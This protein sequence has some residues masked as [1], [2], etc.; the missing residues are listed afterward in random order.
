MLQTKGINASGIV[1]DLLPMQA[2][3][4][5][6]I[7]LAEPIQTV[8]DQLCTLSEELVGDCV[9]SVMAYNNAGTGL[10]VVSAPNLPDRAIEA[11]DGLVP[12]YG[13]GSCANAVATGEPTIVCDVMIDNVWQNVRDLAKQFKL[14]A[15]W[16]FPVYINGIVSGSFA[17]SSFKTREPSELH[18][19]LLKTSAHLAGLALEREENNKILR[20]SDLAFNSTS[21]GMMIADDKGKVYKSN[22]AY[23]EITGYT[24]ED[25][26][27]KNFIDLVSGDDA[28]K[29]EIKS[30][31][32][33][34]G[35]WRGEVQ[36]LRKDGEAVPV[37]ANISAVENNKKHYITVL[38]DISVL[39]ASE[40][41]LSY[42]A[43]HDVLT[44]L[45]NR[46][47]FEKTLED[48]LQ[49]DVSESSPVAVLFV[50]LDDFKIINDSQGH[51][52]GDKMLKQV[53]RRLRECVRDTDIVA[54]LGGD[55]F[56]LL[57]PFSDIEAVNKLAER[58]VSK[59]SQPYSI[60]KQEYFSSAS[61]GI[62][63]APA[64]GLTHE[65]LIKHADAAMYQ[66][67]HLGKN[68]FCFYTSDLTRSLQTRIMMEAGLRSAI[69]KS[70]F[71][72]AYQPRF[73][74][75]RKIIAV[76][77][78]LRWTSE[79]FGVVPPDEFIHL[80]ERA[81]IISELGEW[82]LLNACLQL[83]SW[84]D[85]GLD[86]CIS[87]NVSR[88]QLYRDFDQSLERVLDITGIDPALLELEIT[89]S[90]MLEELDRCHDL[91]QAINDKGVK[92]SIDDFGTGYSSLSDLKN[93]PVQS[94]KIDKS[95]VKGL[96]DNEDDRAIAH[97]VIAMGHAQK[98]NVV[99]EGVET[100]RQLESLAL[101]GCDEY[102]GYLL[103]RPVTADELTRQLG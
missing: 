14:G 101:M 100:D 55:E 57:V 68:R 16:S 41:R 15:C 85:A 98:L 56:T 24:A 51:A 50:D 35:N 83:K 9:A 66:A 31:I 25:I 38:S 59:I 20:D 44:D 84:T 92:I 103:S 7:A 80:A 65:V 93:L 75:E 39:K 1:A 70:E 69:Q 76:E 79:E 58:I 78:L 45:P 91:L 52:T 63:V 2:E 34:K 26:K 10:H 99:A 64:D 23:H 54:R 47:A 30:A 8:L 19:Q 95:L 5:E 13:V 29:Q 27:N 60:D 18:E 86:V 90:T 22:P 28:I 82:V 102:Q 49:T 46:F 62:A 96:P 89:E 17:I 71:S 61:L 40:R 3:I 87:V 67:K 53:G 43:H 11:L 72:I 12:G 6:A 74:N 4:L 36:V 21:E 33:N 81:G 48:T 42:L 88:H 94:L 32:S 97:A 73:N 77:A 37:L